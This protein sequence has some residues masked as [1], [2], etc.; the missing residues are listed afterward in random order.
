MTQPGKIYLWNEK[1]HIR[2]SKVCIRRTII[3]L[4]RRKVVFDVRLFDLRGRKTIVVKDKYLLSC[5][6]PSVGRSLRTYR[7]Q[8]DSNAMKNK[9]PRRNIRSSL[10]RLEKRD[11]NLEKNNEYKNHFLSCCCNSN[12]CEWYSM[13]ACISKAKHCIRSVELT[14]RPIHTTFYCTGPKTR[15]VEKQGVTKMLEKKHHWTQKDEWT[16]PI[17]L[18]ITMNEDL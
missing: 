16:V 6:Q 3:R 15:E 18:K 10:V 9:W 12:R 17:V 4:R 11:Q 8:N 13:S 2:H 14:K 1:I 5:N 7:S